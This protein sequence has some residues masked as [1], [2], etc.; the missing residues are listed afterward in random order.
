MTAVLLPKLIFKARLTTMILLGV[1]LPNLQLGATQRPKLRVSLAIQLLFGE[2]IV[3]KNY[4]WRD[5]FGRQPWAKLVRNEFKEDN[6]RAFGTPVLGEAFQVEVAIA[7]EHCSPA[8]VGKVRG[9]IVAALAAEHGLDL[10]EPNTQ[11]LIEHH[12]RGKVIPRLL[13]TVYHD[14]VTEC[15]WD[16]IKRH[17]DPIVD[18]KSL[19]RH[20]VRLTK[21]YAED[22]FR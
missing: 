5:K 15:L 19:R 8:L 10:M 4:A 9:K 11:R 1:L 22:L 2:G 21:T 6:R 16:A 13:E 17:R 3:L 18:F 7:E 14:V 20:C 12:Y